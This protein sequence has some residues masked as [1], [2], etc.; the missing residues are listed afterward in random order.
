MA[1]F[2]GKDIND[3]ENTS[4]VDLSHMTVNKWLDIW[5]EDYVKPNVRIKSY[6]RYETCLRY[7][8]KPYLGNLL[9]QNVTALE[10]QRV[11]TRLRTSGGTKKSGISST[12]IRI[13]RRYLCMAFERAY[14][15]EL[16][17]RNVIKNTDPPKQVQREIQPLT[18]SEI[19]RLLKHAK[20]MDEVAYLTI[21]LAV[22]TGM[23]LGEILGLKW[24]CVDT[25]QRIIYVKRTIATNTKGSPFQEPKTNKSRRRI[26]IPK[27]VAEAIA[28]YKRWQSAYILQKGINY[29]RL[30]LVVAN[31]IG[32]PLSSSNFNF[33]LYKP[34]LKKANLKKETRFHDLR[35]THATLLL[36]KGVNPKVVQERL[37]HST[38]TITLD[39]YSHVLPDMQQTAV[40]ALEG[41]ASS[42]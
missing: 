37:G 6:I 15:L 36:S 17:T 42:N 41:I 18:E 33:R 5:L 38:I 1:K 32:R 14:K 30:D 24:D 7:Y 21:L 2:Q 29:D 27:D 20:E 16:L 19:Q 22:S 3:I 40:I 10:V 11:F 13:T 34:L 8:I 28:R 9:L 26:P 35:H 39:T 4:L 23:R 31:S 12:T 25:E